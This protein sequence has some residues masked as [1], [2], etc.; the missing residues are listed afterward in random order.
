M[1]QIVRRVVL[2]VVVFSGGFPVVTLSGVIGA[3][4]VVVAAAGGGR[5]MRAAMHLAAHNGA[6]VSVTH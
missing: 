4:A 2:D 3:A 5:S 1:F 6:P